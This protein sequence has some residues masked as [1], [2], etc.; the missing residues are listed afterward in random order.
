MTQLDAGKLMTP[1]NTPAVDGCNR[2]PDCTSDA[3]AGSHVGHR[4]PVEHLGD[5]KRTSHIEGTKPVKHGVTL[6]V[7]GESPARSLDR[8]RSFTVKHEPGSHNE[9][10]DDTVVVCLRIR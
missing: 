9:H 6:A 7:T 8:E 1:S 10:D 3:I 4:C 5:R 2:A